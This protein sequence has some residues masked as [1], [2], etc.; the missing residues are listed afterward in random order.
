[1]PKEPWLGDKF[2]AKIWQIT[3]TG[4]NWVLLTNTSSFPKLCFGFGNE[5]LVHAR[6]IE[7]LYRENVSFRDRDLKRFKVNDV[8]CI[9]HQKILMLNFYSTYESLTS[10]VTDMKYYSPTFFRTPL[11][12]DP[13]ISS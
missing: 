3:G 10:Y 9:W 8:I 5:N 12:T 1:M 13:L 2:P 4:F 7:T 11:S 6:L